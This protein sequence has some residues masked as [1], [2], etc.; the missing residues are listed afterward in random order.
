[1][2]DRAM[3]IGASSG[4]GEALAHELATEGYEVGLTARS[5]ETLREIAEGLPTRAYVKRMDVTETETARDAFRS[6]AGE[7]DG[8][9]V[10]VVNA[11]IGPGNPELDWEPERDTIDTNVR[12]FTAMAVAAMN[13]FEQQG[14]GQLVGV[15][16]VA[17]YVGSSRVPAYYAS[18]AYVS[19]YLDGLRY[20]S[21][22]LDADITVTTVEPGFVDTDLAGGE[23]WMCSPE[24]AAELI[25]EAIE[26]KK[27]Q[28]FVTRRWRLVATALTVMPDVLKRRLF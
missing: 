18:K 25:R 11:G 9:D 5:V 17:S 6:L 14:H 7:M 13:Y 22:H 23:F 8:V 10:V 16:S 1:M 19:N 28:Q 21:R 3:V 12:G 24:T 27:R 4:I 26:E 2:T 20:R 15:S